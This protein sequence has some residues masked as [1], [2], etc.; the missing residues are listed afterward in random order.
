VRLNPE[1]PYMQFPWLLAQDGL[2]IDPTK[3][4][5]DLAK[6]ESVQQVLAVVV[7]V[8]L[9]ALASLVIYHVRRELHHERTKQA[10]SKGSNDREDALRI[11]YEQRVDREREATTAAMRDLNNTLKGL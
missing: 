6:A 9:F 10:N 8:L 11:H 3:I 2:T 1:R 7:G 5:Q 4:A